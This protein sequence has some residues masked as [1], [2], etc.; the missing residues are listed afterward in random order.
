[1]A[2]RVKNLDDFQSEIISAKSKID[3]HTNIKSKQRK[4]VQIYF[5]RLEKGIRATYIIIYYL[6]V[7]FKNKDDFHKEIIFAIS[8]IDFH[9]K[10]AKKYYKHIS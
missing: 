5:F 3:F 7:F 8:N 2:E 9:T 10:Q 6:N 4:I 1:M